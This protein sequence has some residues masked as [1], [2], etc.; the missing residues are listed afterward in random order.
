M[1]VEQLTE[2]EL[3]QVGIG[4]TAK[5]IRVITVYDDHKT[6][7]TFQTEY[8]DENLISLATQN[9]SCIGNDWLNWDKTDQTFPEIFCCAE[10]EIDIKP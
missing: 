9:V 10:L 1:T 2:I 5:Y 3:L 7:A 6:G 8:F 4:K